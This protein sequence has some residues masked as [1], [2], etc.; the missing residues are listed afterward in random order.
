MSEIKKLDGLTQT[1]DLPC[2]SMCREKTMNSYRK[3]K[4]WAFAIF[5]K[6]VRDEGETG[7]YKSDKACTTCRKYAT[8]KK[9]SKTAQGKR[10]DKNL[11]DFY[12]GAADGFI[13]AYNSFFKSILTCL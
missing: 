13:D 5:N 1:A 8:D 4:R 9:L 11:R 6:N 7:V 10:L 12:K 2:R 3:G